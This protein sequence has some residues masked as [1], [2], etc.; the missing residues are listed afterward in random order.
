MG[1]TDHGGLGCFLAL[2]P[3]QEAFD[4]SGEPSGRFCS[5]L[6]RRLMKNSQTEALEKM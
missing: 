4:E 3:I 2:C 6:Q 1:H 5:H